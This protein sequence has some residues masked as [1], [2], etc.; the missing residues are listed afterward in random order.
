MPLGISLSTLS[1]RV[2]RSSST[3]GTGIRRIVTDAT[4]AIRR[5]QEEEPTNF[6]DG[7]KRFGASILTSVTWQPPWLKFSFSG[8]FSTFV[9]N[10]R[11]L[12]NFNW[13]STDAQ[14]DEQI[15][16]MEIAIASARGAARGSFAGY[17]ICGIAPTA[18]LAVFNE[19]LALYTLAN[20]GEE[21]A[22]EIAANVSVLIQLTL[23]KAVKSTFINIFKNYRNLLRPAAIGFAR[24]LQ[25][26]GILDQ[27]SVD[28]ANKKRN[29]PW[30][31]ASALEDTIDRIEDP[32]AQAETEEFWDEF[33]EACIEAGYIVAGSLDSYF[34]QQ[35]V[36]EN[37]ASGGADHTII[38]STSGA[39]SAATPT[40][41]TST[42]S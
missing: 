7:L 8:L 31:I 36:Q 18:A 33:G 39:I 6:W 26:A 3:G 35:K 37:A 16:Q 9:S 34:M 30:S 32:V 2:T 19:P 23:Q 41:S 13:N 24:I 5:T 22:E 10:V 40:T 20:V 17:L 1:S 27:E 4:S 15:K 21:A 11:Q 14:L 12:L 28:K 38:M 25:S 29:E 42:S